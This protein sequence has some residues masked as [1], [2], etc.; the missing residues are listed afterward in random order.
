MKKVT[1]EEIL[2]NIRNIISQKGMKQCVVAERAGF[3]KQELSNILNGHKLLRV[4]H[5][6]RLAEAL[7]VEIA[8]LYVQK[9][10]PTE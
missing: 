8:E 10:C 3:T 2:G 9:N 5:I 6:P 4:E 7:G 1:Y